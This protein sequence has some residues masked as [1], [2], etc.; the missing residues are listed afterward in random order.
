[1]AHFDAPQY[2]DMPDPYDHTLGDWSTHY[3]AEPF[4][5]TFHDQYLCKI[6]K[7]SQQILII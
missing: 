7:E 6:M 3:N 2:E 1:M 4:W 5:G